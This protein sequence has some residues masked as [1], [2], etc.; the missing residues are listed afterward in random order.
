[1]P[2]RA[3]P[4]VRRDLDAHLVVFHD[5]NRF[6]GWG[7]A[8]T[9]QAGAFSITQDEATF[10]KH[11]KAIKKGTSRYHAA[12]KALGFRSEAKPDISKLKTISKEH[13]DGRGACFSFRDKGECKFGNKCRFSHD[14]AQIRRAR[15]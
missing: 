4:G 9:Q 11:I 3:T 13:K 7:G 10:M 8:D 2:Q 12:I 1:M 15:E 6:L 5:T 14:P